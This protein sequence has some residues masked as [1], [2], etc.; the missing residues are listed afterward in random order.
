[1]TY[2]TES[3]INGELGD[4][5][6]TRTDLGGRLA[7]IGQVTRDGQPVRGAT[8]KLEELTD[9][10]GNRIRMYQQ[11]KLV[12][13]R[14]WFDHRLPGT[15]YPDTSTDGGGFFGLKAQFDATKIP[16]HGRIVILGAARG[17]CVLF[18]RVNL[19]ALPREIDAAFQALRVTPKMRRSL[20][21]RLEWA[22]KP[23]RPSPEQLRW[24]A[25]LTADIGASPAVRLC[26]PGC[27]TIS[28]GGSRRCRASGRL[29][30]TSTAMSC[31]GWESDPQSFAKVI[32]EH[33]ARTEYG[34]RDRG[35]PYW[36]G[37]KLC[38]VRFPG[39]DVMVSFARV[40]DYVIARATGRNTPRREYEYRCFSDGTIRFRPRRRPSK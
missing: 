6:G 29:G 12:R 17:D 2:Q 37:K 15:S 5:G 18:V 22:L 30:G 1:M 40:P 16:S 35:D 13:R 19:V 11:G 20:R 33:Y 31:K 8:V 26:V 34:Q 38:T 27:R 10:G 28:V 23:A 4:F 24:G 9:V 36:C 3:T 32:A 21:T 39:R 25:F 14:F 7:I